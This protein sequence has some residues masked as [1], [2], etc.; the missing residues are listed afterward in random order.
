MPGISSF[1]SLEGFGEELE[2][3]GSRSLVSAHWWKCITGPAK[4]SDQLARRPAV[5]AD[6]HDIAQ[7]AVLGAGDAVEDI[8]E[9]VCGAATGEDNNATGFRGD[10]LL[11]GRLEVGDEMVR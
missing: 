1:V 6:G 8:D 3:E 4:D 5:V 9:V 7:G 2:T 10:H 11:G